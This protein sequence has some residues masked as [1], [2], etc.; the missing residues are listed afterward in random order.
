MEFFETLTTALEA[1]KLNKM[2]TALA[3]LGI[4]IGIGAV[5]ALVSLGQ[6]SQQTV[7]TQIQSLGSNMLTVSPGAQNSGGIRGASGG[8]TTLT[9]DDAKAIAPSTQITTVAKVSP[10]L[11]RR[12]QIIAGRNN[13]NAQ[14]LGA[15]PAYADV[16]KV[17]VSSGRFLSQQDVDGM[18]RVAVLGP[19]AIS[20]LFPSGASPIGQSIRISNISFR[21][22]GVTTSKGGTGFMNQDDIA[23][24]PLTTA[25]KLVF[26]VNYLG[27]ISIEAKSADVMN[28]ARD[29]VG[30]FLLA[31]HKITN[32]YQADFSIF[33][34]EDILG[35]ATQ[36]TGT[37]T[38]L[39]SGIATISLL[40]GGIGIM[41]VM[42][43]TVIERTREIGLRKSLGARDRD[44]VSQFLAEAVILT[45]VGGFLGMIIGVGLSYI[46][47]S[48]MGLPFTL[49]LSAVILAIGVSGAIG[50]VFGLYPARKAARLSP[51]EA[52]RFE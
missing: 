39:L 44:V 21:V 52:L 9:N 15:T 28:Q 47:S 22:I 40:V 30:Y 31:R 41:N 10:E 14:I 11:S 5:I 27:S 42:L 48:L 8:G 25:Q 3:M 16:R 26:G 6:A 38:M 2:R 46:I 34:Q 35:A 7:Q 12:A 33:S 45:V 50:I 29:Q 18:Q 24:I 43:I 17:T 13:E 37:F 1:L 19:T 4:V 32:P 36:V 51:I 20:N 23:I 49:S